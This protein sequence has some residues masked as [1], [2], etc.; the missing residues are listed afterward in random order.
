MIPNNKGARSAHVLDIKAAQ[1][2]CKDAWA[3]RSVSTN[4]DTPQEDNKG[5]LRIMKK[6]PE[7]RYGGLR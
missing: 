6:K 1:F 5:H 4:I 2:A 3:K 7:A